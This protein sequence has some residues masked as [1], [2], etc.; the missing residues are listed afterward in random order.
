MQAVLPA[1]G[2]VAATLIL[3]VLQ[4]TSLNTLLLSLPTARAT[5]QRAPP[6]GH[7]ALSGCTAPGRGEAALPSSPEQ[8]VKLERDARLSVHHCETSQGQSCRSCWRP[9]ALPEQFQQGKQPA[10]DSLGNN[11]QLVLRTEYSEKMSDSSAGET[12]MGILGKSALARQKGNNPEVKDTRRRNT[13]F[14][15]RKARSSSL[16]TNSKQSACLTTI[17]LLMVQSTLK[18]SLAPRLHS[19]GLNTQSRAGSH[20]QMPTPFLNLSP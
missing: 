14:H 18:G 3:H 8:A 9:A 7:A 19:S 11:T 20:Q 17:T 10:P 5:A 4:E 13:A 12:I 16:A 6:L 2:H 1:E 15:R